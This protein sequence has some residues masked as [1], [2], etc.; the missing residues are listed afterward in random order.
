M[1]LASRLRPMYRI[2]GGKPLPPSWRWRT[3]SRLEYKPIRERVHVA[4]M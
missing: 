3:P 2:I 1:Y 4:A